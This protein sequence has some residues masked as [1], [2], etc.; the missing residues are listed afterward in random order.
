MMRQ[1]TNSDVPVLKK[2][3]KDIFGDTDSFIDWFFSARF[4][5]NM[6]FCTEINGEIASVIH[7]YPITLYLSEK[8]VSAVMISG[9]STIPLYRN[10]GLMRKLF[11]YALTQLDIAGF[12]LCCYYPTN[13]AFYQSLGHTIFTSNLSVNLFGMH[14]ASNA[15]I[16]HGTLS[17]TNSADFKSLYFDFAK[18]YSGIVLRE[19]DFNVKFS[20]YLSE[21]MKFAVIF[22]NTPV[23]YIIYA[24]TD[25]HI[26]LAEAVGAYS[27]I[28]KLLSTFKLPVNGNLPPDF[29]TEGLSGNFRITDGNMGGI[30]NT[31]RFL[32]ETAFCCPLTIRISDAAVPSNCGN[33][34]FCGNPSAKS[35]DITLSSGELL[36][37]LSGFEV[38]SSLREFFPERTCFSMDLY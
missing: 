3:W 8:K 4:N 11:L 26:E 17:E 9:V 10:R 20:E 6:S 31:E 23:A 36:Q 30:I 15:D 34:D 16:R 21:K 29:P 2:I 24:E 28:K 37:A 19:K 13:S 32:A 5:P 25:S 12:S 35:P 1:T 18:N 38:P 27:N 7:S 22:E 14:G 33:F